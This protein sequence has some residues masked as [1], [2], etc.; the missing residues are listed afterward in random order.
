M[1]V[2]GWFNMSSSDYLRGQM[3]AESLANIRATNDRAR[4]NAH[5]RIAQYEVN[6]QANAYNQ[7]LG[8]YNDLVNRFNNLLDEKQS[9]QE[10]AEGIKAA[11]SHGD[12]AYESLQEA[13]QAS[14]NALNISEFQVSQ[15]KSALNDSHVGWYS[16]VVVKTFLALMTDLARAR[17]GSEEQQRRFAQIQQWV[18][19]LRNEPNHEVMYQD[20]V[21]TVEKFGRKIA[22]NAVFR[23]FWN[24][25]L[26]LLRLQ[27]DTPQIKEIVQQGMWWRQYWLDRANN[28]FL[29]VNWPDRPEALRTLLLDSMAMTNH[30]LALRFTELFERNLIRQ[31]LYALEMH[32]IHGAEGGLRKPVTPQE[33][34]KANGSDKV[35]W[36][37]YTDAMQMTLQTLPFAEFPVE[38][39]QFFQATAQSVTQGYAE[40]MQWFLTAIDELHDRR[41]GKHPDSPPMAAYPEQPEGTTTGDQ[42]KVVNGAAQTQGKESAGIREPNQPQPASP[43]GAR[44]LDIPGAPTTPQPQGGNGWGN[45]R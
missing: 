45:S 12:A 27:P 18:T 16:S 40:R 42:R 20:A 15:L 33:I 11:K 14:E 34:W 29:F 13:L 44:T 8:Q 9:W 19:D 36:T 32:Q 43:L 5:A 3:A 26:K 10:Y 6:Q 39:Q 17:E 4:A 37:P 2:Q 7:L 31:F 1:R 22:D 41:W 21:N 23:D 30:L 28:T 24:H 38:L 35:A 25:E